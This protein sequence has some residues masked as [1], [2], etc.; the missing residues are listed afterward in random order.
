MR[1]RRTYA[2]LILAA[3]CIAPIACQ[4]G[5]QPG[6]GARPQG[7]APQTVVLVSLDGFRA[8]YITRPGAVRLR[9]LAAQGV[10]AGRMVPAFPSKTFPN[11]WSIVTGLYPEHHGIVAN[12]MRDSV[13][14]RFAIGD[15]PAV[16]D[17]RWFLGEP[18]WVTAE[19]Q[20]VR[21]AANLWPG[22]E[23]E[24]AGVRPSWWM[25]FDPQLA[26]AEKVRMTLELLALPADS[27]PRFVTTYFSDVDHAGHE[28]GPGD[29]QV[30]S[31]IARVDSAVGALVDGIAKLPAGRQVNLI[32]VA[33]H[34]MAEVSADRLIFLDDYVSLDSLDVV[35]WTPV[36]AIAPKPGHDRYVLS[37][38]VNANPHLAVYRKSEVPA[39]FHFSEG[40]RITPV[41][42][43]ADEGWTITSHKG[44][45][46]TP[47][48]WKGGAH[49]YDNQLP[50]MGALFVAAGPAFRTGVVVAPFQ[51]IHVY[52]L[53]ANVLGLKPAATD[54]SLDSVRVLLRR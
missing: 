9:A 23:A 22:S 49:G 34:G 46:R 29:P 42:A 15:D 12:V 3:A 16:R 32:V 2:T 39:R 28:F 30:D 47:P 6:A 41:V 52:S 17:G 43:I 38:L 51:N 36:A 7:P 21:T 54:G 26:R 48:G 50:S 24:I 33:D 18:I 27:A 25:R 1:W 40:G 35:D 19:K 8:D 20:H 44:A 13:L 53:L 37:R 31:A 10:R 14:G 5:A 45:D 11:H 4:R